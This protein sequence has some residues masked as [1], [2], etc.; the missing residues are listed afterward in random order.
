MLVP[1]VAAHGLP[2]KAAY[3]GLRNMQA[4]FR[5]VERILHDLKILVYHHNTSVI[6]IR[7]GLDL[8][9]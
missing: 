7:N 3:H 1:V 9:V 4:A 5:N 8:T 2:L 6:D